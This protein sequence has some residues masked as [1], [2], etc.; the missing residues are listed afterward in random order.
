MKVKPLV[1]FHSECN[2]FAGSERMLINFFKNEE[3]RS[4]FKIFFITGNSEKY[5]RELSYFFEPDFDYSQ[6]GF[7]KQ[8]HP[9]SDFK[10]LPRSIS[11]LCRKVTEILYRIPI[12]IIDICLLI[13]HLRRIKPDIVH[14]NNGGYPGSPSA[15]AMVLASRIVG[16]HSIF[17]VVNNEALDYQPV[18]RWFDRPTDWLVCGFITN[19]ITGSK[20]SANKLINVLKL[21]RD[22]IVSLPNGVI[23]RDP[24]ESVES[25]RRRVGLDDM[26]C[27]LVGLVVSRFEYR[28]GHLVLLDALEI[29]KK[30]GLIS[31]NNLRIIFEGNGPELQ[32]VLDVIERLDLSSI[33][34]FVGDERN[35]ANLY[36]ASDFLILPSIKEEDFSNVISESMSHGL[37]VI[38]TDV[39]GA[40]EQVSDGQTGFIVS[41]NHPIELSDVILRVIANPEVVLVAGRKGKD[42]YLNN[43]TPEI[44]VKRYFDLYK[45]SIQN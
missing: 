17:M 24:D 8:F 26:F 35:I 22:K 9:S 39:A 10:Y 44:A 20:S 2:F 23:H 4:E 16:V 25:I 42:R 27:G 5:L 40:R 7:P 19:F 31:S 38:A 45:E 21:D 15:R 6:I 41:P 37:C 28:K 36:A 14:I 18:H 30:S 13:P 43:F 11:V 33:V 12:V 32:E 29:L 1:L 34:Q 3:F